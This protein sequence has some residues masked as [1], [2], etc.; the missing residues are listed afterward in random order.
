MKFPTTALLL[1]LPLLVLALP[2]TGSQT[3]HVAGEDPVT[4]QIQYVC[5]MHSHIVKDHPGQCP[6]CG[7]DLEPVIRSVGS[8]D[9]QGQITVSGQMQQAMSLVTEPVRRDDLWKYIQTLGTATFDEADISHIHPRVSG[10]LESLTPHAVGEPVEKGELLFTLYSPELVVAQDDYLQVLQH[11]NGRNQQRMLQQGRLRLKLLGIDDEVIKQLEDTGQSLYTV[12]FYAKRSG[13]IT[14]LNVRHGMYVTPDIEMLAIADL[15][16]LW[17]IADVFENQFD[18]LEEGR[19]ASIHFSGI[20]VHDA[21]ATIDYIYPQ[22]DPVTRSLKVRLK[23]DNPL[24]RIKAGMTARV[25]IFGGPLRDV[26]VVSSSAVIRGADSDR[27]VVQTDDN[28]FAVRRVETGMQAQGKTEI[29]HGLSEGERVV[30]SGQFLLDSEASLAGGLGRLD[31][32]PHA[33]H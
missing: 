19:P 22:L 25:E 3:E 33:G 27:V 29:L 20:G 17:V 2:V 28:A 13:V 21:E 4:G 31:A 5:P 30:T 16:K 15:S 14:E 26:L 32:D 24:R 10:W 9:N 11:N 12:P 6:I 7:M 23:L 1:M 8:D 18:W